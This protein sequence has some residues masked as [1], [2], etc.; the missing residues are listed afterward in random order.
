MYCN[1]V[2]ES[3]LK[4]L[5]TTLARISQL[6]YLC[7]L[8]KSRRLL[9]LMKAGPLSLPR[10]AK[11]LYGDV[12]PYNEARAEG[13]MDELWEIGIVWCRGEF[14]DYDYALTQKGH[15]HLENLL[16]S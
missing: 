15:E 14:L 8:A 11:E 2:T 7:S 9:K 16:D 3:T 1:M 10:I 13:A 12:N 6:P 4:E 5:K